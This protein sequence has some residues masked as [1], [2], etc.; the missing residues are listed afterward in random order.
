MR[1]PEQPVEKSAQLSGRRHTFLRIAWLC[2]LTCV[3][4]ISLAPSDSTPKRTMDALNVS[5]KLLHFVAYFVLMLL[6]ALH[7]TRL[8]T[9]LHAVGIVALGITVE[10]LQSPLAGRPFDA[11]DVVANLAGV[12]AALVAA[13]AGPRFSLMQSRGA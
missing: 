8:S 12:L 7:E 3:V 5:D 2:T 9:A 13:E 6:P 1:A 11:G 4:A 10:F